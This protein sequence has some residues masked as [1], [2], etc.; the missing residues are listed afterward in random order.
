MSRDWHRRYSEILIL[1]RSNMADP[2]RK[3][4]RLNLKTNN[5]TQ[6]CGPR[7][8]DNVDDFLEGCHK[9]QLLKSS[10]RGLLIKKE[11]NKKTTNYR[12][13]LLR[14]TL[15]FD[16]TCPFASRVKLASDFITVPAA[17]KCGSKFDQSQ[18]PRGK[19]GIPRARFRKVEIYRKHSHHVCLFTFSLAKNFFFFFFQAKD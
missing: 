6:I 8:L 3:W 15:G 12:A 18:G 10:I 16:S 1:T 7:Y 14:V 9:N 17:R 11:E 13:E 19:S 4:Q 5:I 2:Q